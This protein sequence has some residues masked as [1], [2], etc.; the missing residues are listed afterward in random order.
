M[1]CVTV[2]CCWESVSFAF[3]TPASA[4]A[5]VIVS[6]A[7]FCG[8]SPASV[9]A[10]CACAE[11]SDERAELTASCALVGSTLPSTCP[12]RTCWPGLTAT[13]VIWPLV[14]KLTAIEL[15]AWTVPLAETDERTTPFAA[16][17]VRTAA[18]GV[19]AGPTSR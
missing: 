19:L 5:T 12:L 8:V 1:S 14:L 13:A 9:C 4:W 6:C 15:G 16:V 18:A 7:R 11:C 3:F 17:E 10:S 2:A